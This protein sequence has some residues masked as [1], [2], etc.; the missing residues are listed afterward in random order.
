MIA[1]EKQ[2]AF[3][4]IIEGYVQEKFSGSTKEEATAYISRNVDTY[5]KARKWENEEMNFSSW[6]FKYS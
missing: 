4:K 6:A 1:T 2:L 3:I 5:R